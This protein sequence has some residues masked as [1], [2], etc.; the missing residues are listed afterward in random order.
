MSY[1][2]YALSL[3]GMPY[4]YW[5]GGPIP[6]DDST[7]F[8]ASNSTTPSHKLFETQGICCTG[9]INLICRRFNTPVPGTDDP[10]MMYPG[11]IGAWH[12]HLKPHLTPF[13]PTIT[14]PDGTLLFRPYADSKDQGHIALIL[15]GKTVH[16]FAYVFEPHTQGIMDPGVSVTPVWPDYYVY[17]APLEAWLFTAAK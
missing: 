3:V 17:A 2:Q 14:Y 13:D 7:P 1:V 15:N 9:L 5:S 12:T 11:G 8:Y 16:S 6:R 10:E 4:G